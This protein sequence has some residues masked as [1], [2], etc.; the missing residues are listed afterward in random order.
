MGGGVSR[1]LLMGGGQQ[2]WHEARPQTPVELGNIAIT[3]AGRLNARHIFHAA[4]LDYSRRS[5]T[6]IDLVRRVT[7]KCLATC[8]G[9]GLH[10]IAFPALA[11]GAASL[12][13]ERSAVAMLIET[14]EHIVNRTSIKLVIIA[15]YP[16]ADLPHD[17][18][19]RFYSQVTDFLEL[20][21]RVASITNALTNLEKIYRELRFDESAN[22]V[23][24]SRDS[25]RQRKAEWEEEM[26]EREPND[27]RRESRWNKRRE[28][29]EPDLE[30]ITS[31]LERRDKEFERIRG[32]PKDWEQLEYDSI[33]YRKIAV[34]NM[35]TIRKKNI[36]DLELELARLGF[37][38]KLNRQLEHEKEELS[39]LETELTKLTE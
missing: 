17:I 11:T 24:S 23:A 26:L 19:P 18:L 13:P 20:T 14:A 15:L 27:Y 3:S 36:T 37:S 10:S 6:T 32:I 38:T 16:R 34:Q 28:S 30:R 12:S 4:V 25:L 39:R 33:K 31:F 29:L 7:K 2:V 35:I 9:L 22:T 5:L 21:E 8:N 1:A